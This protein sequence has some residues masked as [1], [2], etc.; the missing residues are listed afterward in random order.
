[1]K[2]ATQTALLGLVVVAA[3]LLLGG[4][5]ASEAGRNRREIGGCV[6]GAHQESSMAVAF[7]GGHYVTI[8]A[9]VLTGCP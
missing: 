1:M 4:A 9:P 7:R 3:L 6:G 2:R 5:A 8:Q